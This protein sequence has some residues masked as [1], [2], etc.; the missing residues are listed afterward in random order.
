MKLYDLVS[1]HGRL[2]L[3]RLAAAALGSSLATVVVLALVNR[4]AQ[5]IAESGIDE[6][7]WPLALVFVGALALYVLAELYLLGRIAAHVE[8]CID[9]ARTRLVERLRQIDLEALERL[10]QSRLF[11]SITQST[12]VISQN[13]QYIAIAFRS[14]ILAVVLFAYVLYISRVAFLLVVLVVVVAGTLYHRRGRELLQSHAAA[15]DQD[16]R[17]FER[18]T[19]QL[20][21]WKE[22]R[23]RRPR[24][25]ALARDFDEAAAI[26]AQRRIEAQEKGFEQYI[27]G[28]VAFY[29]LLGVV[30][31]LVPTYSDVFA[32]DLVQIATAVLFL[33][34]PI[35]LVI[36]ASTVLSAAEAAAA[37]ILATDAELETL[38]AK[39]RGNGR[40]AKPP[41]DFAE[42]RLK[43]IEYGYP[44]AS[45]E[46]PF[47]LGPLD[48]EVRKGEIVFVSGGNGSGKSTLV[49][50]LTGLYQP[51]EGCLEVDGRRIGPANVDSYRGLVAAVLSDFHLFRRLHGLEAVS[52][53][54]VERE[55][56]Y[57]ELEGIV[58]LGE[59]GFTSIDLSAGQRKRLALAV[60][61]LEGRPLLVLDE[62]AADQDPQFRRRFYREILPELRERGLT[63]VAVTHDDHYYDAA[64]RRFHL[65]EGR[66][67]EVVGEAAAGA[68]EG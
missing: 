50:I 18:V 31:F 10:G 26:A 49:K 62:W 28:Q 48:I 39:A 11:E 3:R 51:Q 55:L 60:A 58:A 59:E 47:H 14:A 9:A 38:A 43:G 13:S 1:R 66:L 67:A 29:L 52:P 17:L 16:R 63:V 27:F 6:V 12:Q 56:R 2:P 32:D 21:G 8:H 34:A 53:E 25:D 35:G 4:A 24:R 41:A 23:M 5:E 20:D 40:V 36:Q 45:D 19:D 64:D 42:I 37:R 44:P 54:R 46:H 33:V 68:G 57:F 7:D 30:V 61:L 65:A 22:V 15:L